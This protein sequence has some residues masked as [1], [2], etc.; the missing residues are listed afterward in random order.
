M[1]AT[2]YRP[3]PT[4]PHA[5][6]TSTGTADVQSLVSPAGAQAVLLTVETTLAYLTTDGSTPSA[7]NGLA[8]PSGVVHQLQI[9]AGLTLKVASSA[10][11][12]SKVNA[13][14]LA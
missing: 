11:A 7:V 14:W 3:T 5:Q 4:T 12:A 6:V 13:L 1:R 10:A 8:L 9:A 2:A